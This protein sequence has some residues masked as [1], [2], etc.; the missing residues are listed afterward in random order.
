MKVLQ[1]I[2][3]ILAIAL[4]VAFFLPWAKIFFFTGSGYDIGVQLGGQA[5]F[6][7]SIPAAAVGI[8]ALA[9][10]GA[11]TRVASIVAGLLPALIAVRVYSKL[12]GDLFEV[13]AIGSYVSLITGIL[14]ILFGVGVVKSPSTVKVEENI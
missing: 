13:L 5:K 7:W 2:E 12:G 3:V 11:N 6:V 10:Y 1:R 4:L 14:L 8:V 9:F